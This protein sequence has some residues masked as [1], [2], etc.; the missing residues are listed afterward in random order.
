MLEPEIIHH[1]RECEQD[2][3]LNQ[4][5]QTDP[6]AV[7]LPRLRGILIRRRLILHL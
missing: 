4:D 1:H 6:N 2:R 3:D 5:V 7:D